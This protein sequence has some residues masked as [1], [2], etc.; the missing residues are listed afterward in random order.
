[1][2]NSEF[3]INSPFRLLKKLICPAVIIFFFTSLSLQALDGDGQQGKKDEEK[4]ISLLK[5][6]YREV[7]EL[8]AYKNDS[9]IKREFHVE[10]DG[11]SEN[12]EEHVVVLIQRLEDREKMLLQ[13]TYFK[14]EGKSLTIK[15]ADKMMRIVCSKE[16]DRM[17]I[18][19]CDYVAKELNPLLSK[20]L[21]GIKKKKEILK[22]INKK[23]NSF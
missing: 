2:L 14:P 12:K 11:R 7:V 9:F 13:V 23:R 17:R 1:M 8:G 19:K 6:I 20:M 3:E 10:L 4:I 5:D 22:L 18:E 16:D 15:H 21:Q